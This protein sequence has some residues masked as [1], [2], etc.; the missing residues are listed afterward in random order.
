MKKKMLDQVMSFKKI[1]TDSWKE[2][3]VVHENQVTRFEL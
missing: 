1:K 2:E 3:G